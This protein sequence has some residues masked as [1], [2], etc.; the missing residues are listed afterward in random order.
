M[1]TKVYVFIVTYNFIDRGTLE[2]MSCRQVFGRRDE[3]EE[4]VKWLKNSA[5]HSDVQ[6]CLSEIL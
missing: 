4:R 1:N 2:K 6:I 5:S 3:A